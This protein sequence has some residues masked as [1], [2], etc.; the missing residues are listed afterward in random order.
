MPSLNDLLGKSAL[1]SPSGVS[2]GVRGQIATAIQATSNEIRNI[3]KQLAQSGKAQVQGAVSNALNSGIVDVRSAAIQAVSGDFSGALTTL[4]K[5]PQ[6]VLGAFGASFGLNNGGPLGQNGGTVNT[7]QGAL[8]RADPMLSFQWYCELPTITPI[9][10]APTSLDWSYV[11][12]ATPPFRNFATRDVYAQG[13]NRK[14]VSTYEV[15]A[16]RLNLYADVANKSLGYM[17]AWGGAILAPFTSSEATRGGGFGRPSDYQRPIR[18]YLVDS[19]RS[20]ILMLEYTECWPTNL[21]AL[22]LD[23]GSSTRLT[24]NVNFSVGDVFMTAFGVNKTI[25]GQSL[26]SS[27]T[28]GIVKGAIGLANSALNSI[29]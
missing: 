19:A 17:Q 13:R 23:S 28:G 14:F 5:G 21:D 4:A 10:G 12:E 9:G 18:I 26:L 29:F 8:G 16:L 22:H 27:L 20:L 25:S 2:S 11:E 3:P 15:D 1:S 6:D 7:L 24:Y